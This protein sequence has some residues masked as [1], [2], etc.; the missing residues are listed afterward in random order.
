MEELKTHYKDVKIGLNKTEKEAYNTNAVSEANRVA[1]EY[2]EENTERTE[3]ALAG[4]EDFG[5]RLGKV[6]DGNKNDARK[7][8]ELEGKVT[9]LKNALYGTILDLQEQD[10]ENVGS[11]VIPE[12]VNS[13]PVVDNQKAQLTSV[14]GRTLI[15]NQLAKITQTTTQTTRGITYTPDGSSLLVNGTSQQEENKVIGTFKMVAGHKYLAATNFIQ[16]SPSNT[17]YFLKWKS[18]SYG[19][20]IG[21]G[22]FFTP[23]TTEAEAYLIFTIYG[24]GIEVDCKFTTAIYDLTKMGIDH[25]TTIEEFNKLTRNLD[26]DTYNEGT[27]V[28]VNIHKVKSYSKY[29][30]VDLGTLDWNYQSDKGRFFSADIS[31]LL[32]PYKDTTIAPNITCDGLEVVA[33]NDFDTLDNCISIYNS[34]IFVKKSNAGTTNQQIKPTLRGTIL[35][36]EPI[37]PTLAELLSEVDVDI[38]DMNGIKNDVGAVYDE[39][40]FDRETR[41]INK[42][43]MKE[44]QF[45]YQSDGVFYTGR[46]PNR[47]SKLDWLVFATNGYK[48]IPGNVQT[49]EKIMKTAGDTLYIKDS[50]FSTVEELQ[51]SFKDDDVLYYETKKPISLT[52]K[53]T[54][55]VNLG[56]LIWQNNEVSYGGLTEGLKNVIKKPS[57]YV[58]VANIRCSKYQVVSEEFIAIFSNS[59]CI[60]TGGNLIINDTNLVGKSNAETQSYLSGVILYYET[61][62]PVEDELPEIGLGEVLLNIQT[63]GTIETDGNA[64]ITLNHVVYKPMEE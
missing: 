34:L 18:V 35:Y 38:T 56:T 19:E 42:V 58:E 22:M 37:E 46:L 21:Q 15:V 43:K 63:G 6:E 11:A 49:T 52:K 57:V 47:P 16:G 50:G 53:T 25:I 62:E 23:T 12:R 26:V 48:Q 41:R 4:I 9:D 32:K 36:Y 7:I 44:M 2:I 51:A 20:D 33:L 28:N 1:N 59:I 40:T 14:R 61:V 39:M 3:T 55:K 64:D 30:K 31:N 13:Y 24:S 17:T 54:A 8:E 29:A 60:T 10:Y 5:G 27:P 45:S